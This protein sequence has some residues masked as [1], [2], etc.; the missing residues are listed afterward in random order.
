MEETF[1]SLV[2][3][4]PAPISTPSPSTRPRPPAPAR[5]HPRPGA[6][7]PPSAARCAAPAAPSPQRSGLE[8]VNICPRLGRCEPSGRAS[9][10]LLGGGR[11]PRGSPAPPRARASAGRHTWR[12][13]P[14]ARRDATQSHREVL[15]RGPAGRAGLKGPRGPPFRAGRARQR[16]FPQPGQP[17]AGSRAPLRPARGPSLALLLHPR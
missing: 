7:S 14:L 15:P 4:L 3:P 12:C 13:H 1:S 17:P 2:H 8:A 9:G 11:L 16:R 5:S 10:V 6:P